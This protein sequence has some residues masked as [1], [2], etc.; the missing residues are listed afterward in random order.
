MECGLEATMT[1]PAVCLTNMLSHSKTKTHGSPPSLPSSAHPNTEHPNA[2][3]V[4][5]IRGTRGRAEAAAEMDRLS[6]CS[7]GF[8]IERLSGSWLFIHLL[9][10]STISFYCYSDSFALCSL[11]MCNRI[12]VLASCYF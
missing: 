5:S 9:L 1:R 7:W 12:S 6:A 4:L 8:K 11:Q 10:F 2:F 3:P